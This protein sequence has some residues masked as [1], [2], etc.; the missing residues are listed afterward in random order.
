MTVPQLFRLGVDWGRIIPD[1]PTQNGG[2]LA[3][4]SAVARYR[5]II[6]VSE[7]QLRR[8]RTIPS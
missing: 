1:A 7:A 2:S 3:D 8:T 4:A 6:Q 5:E